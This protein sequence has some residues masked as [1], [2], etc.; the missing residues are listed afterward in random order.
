MS[1]VDT[2]YPTHVMDRE[3][4]EDQQLIQKLLEELPFTNKI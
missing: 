2:L 1:G 3:H 4:G